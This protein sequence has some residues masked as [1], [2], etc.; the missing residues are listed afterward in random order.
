MVRYGECAIVQAFGGWLL[1]AVIG[2][3]GQASAEPYLAIREGLTC[4]GCH[5]NPTGGGLRNSFGN[6]YA[7]QQLPASPLGDDDVWTGEVFSRFGIGAN[8]RVAARQFDSDDRDDSLEFAVDRITVYGNARLN[9]YVSFYVDQQLAPGGS[10]NREAWVKIQWNDFYL[11]GGRM[12]LP[13]GWRLEDNSAF[14]RQVTGVNM[15]RGDDGIEFGYATNRIDAQLAITNGNGGGGEVDDG[16]LV[17]G[18]LAGIW[19][20]FQVGLSGQHNDTD[21]VDRTMFGVFGGFNTGPVAWLAEYDW[22]EDKAAAPDRSVTDNAV[23][24]LEANWLIGRGHVLK[25][26]FE[27]EQPD[28]G[29]EDR[30]RGSLVYEFFPWSFTQLRVGLRIRDSDDPDPRLNT[31]E[32][33]VQLHAFF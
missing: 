2:L 27:I 5:V 24:L 33:F 4:A 23:G 21:Q 28:D 3:A 8:G 10:A 18:R 25:A 7:Q 22:I 32:G 31:D 13:F 15:E 30:M 1:L 16:K 11:R 9:E 12:F 17:S 14:I 19:N 20:N 29:L 26:T 6:I